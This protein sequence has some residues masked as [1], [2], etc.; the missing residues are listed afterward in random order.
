MLNRL[1][2]LHFVRTFHSGVP[3][4]LLS[5]HLSNSRWHMTSPKLWSLV[6]GH[7]STE[8]HLNYVLYSLTRDRWLVLVVPSAVRRWHGQEVR[9]EWHRFRVRSIDRLWGRIYPFYRKRPVNLLFFSSLNMIS[10]ICIPGDVSAKESCPEVCTAE[11]KECWVEDYDTS[12]DSTWVSSN[13]CFLS[14]FPE[15]GREGF[16]PE[17][18][19]H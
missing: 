8:G 11:Q 17:M 16:F 7:S 18:R 5:I 9:T 12:G 10:W 1:C 4:L 2:F 14:V 15:S 6:R 19:C 3:D 13:F